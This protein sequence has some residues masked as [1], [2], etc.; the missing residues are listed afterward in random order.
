MIFALKLLNQEFAEYL[1]FQLHAWDYLH[2]QASTSLQVPCEIA[3][4][5][6]IIGFKQGSSV[7][8]NQITT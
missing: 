7:T 6:L 1:T 3:L 4:I 5:G 2:P 8:F